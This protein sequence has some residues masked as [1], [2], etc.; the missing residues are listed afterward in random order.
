MC[1]KKGANT[2]GKENNMSAAELK[3]RVFDF[4]NRFFFASNFVVEPRH[5]FI[6]LNLW[7][8]ILYLNGFQFT[9]LFHAFL[10]VFFCDIIVVCYPWHGK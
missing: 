1:T 4:K 7:R 6:Y 5:L 2:T 8:F 9:F 10:Q 3:E